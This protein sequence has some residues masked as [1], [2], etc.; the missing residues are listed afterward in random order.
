LSAPIY[1]MVVTE[2]GGERRFGAAVAKRMANLGAL[3]KGDRRAATGSDLS[4]F[5]IDSS[6]GR[7]ALTQVYQCLIEAE[8]GGPVMC[9]SRH[10]NTILDEYVQ[11]A[12][13]VESIPEATQQE[14][15]TRR[16]YA[17]RVAQHA[18]AEIG[19]TSSKKAEVKVFLNRI[20]GLPVLQQNLVFSLF[21]ST[22]DDVV[23][24]AKATGQFE[25]SVEDVKATCIELDGTPETLAVDRRSGATTTLTRLKLDRGI[26]LE[27]VAAGALED[28]PLGDANEESSKS[29]VAE[30]G[31]YISKRI[32]AGR[33]LVLYAKRKVEPDENVAGGGS[34]HD[35]LG[36]MV[37][38]R[39]NTGK[40]P[41]EMHSKD[42]K[43]KYILK[44]SSAQ[45]SKGL[46]D[47][48]KCS[49]N[50]EKAPTTEVGE[51]A[52]ILRRRLP[53]VTHLWDGSYRDSDTFENFGGLAPRRSRL[54]LITGAVLHVLP[55]LEKAVLARTEADRAL[56]V[57]RVELSGSEQ[58]LVGIRFPIDIHVVEKLKNFLKEL[59]DQAK[60]D[61]ASEAISFKDEDLTPVNEKSM[62]WATT[63]R[64]TMRSFF[65]AAPST[66][67]NRTLSG[68]K[69]KE[70]ALR[71]DLVP[72]SL[73]ASNSKPTIGNQNKNNAV[74]RI[75]P[76]S[77]LA[78]K[79]SIKSFFGKK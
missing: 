29:R 67:T 54:G 13:K 45:F 42:L 20:A 12:S 66:Q 76:A 79:G 74:S 22:L 53:K 2:L 24:D 60:K 23:S 10:G 61:V 25:G 15:V 71:S 70:A 7:R 34:V 52:D 35:P 9:P 56:R 58:R 46:K 69:R 73:L 57:A 59:P 78:K 19:L 8:G 43:S 26:S 77:K 28:A 68:T 4:E 32:I 39:P 72:F 55:A 3:T 49:D 27:T 44:M 6:Y 18:L 63:E 21:M 14:E 50:G 40:N 33:Q 41:C 62:A 38:T 30:S 17:L 37:I 47:N 48:E 5:D 75:G 31:F 16:S 1:K 11:K 64:K 65:K 36:L 51:P